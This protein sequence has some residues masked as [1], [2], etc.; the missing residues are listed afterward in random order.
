MQSFYDHDKIV[1]DVRQAVLGALEANGVADAYNAL[2]VGALLE[3]F[4]S[5]IKYQTIGSPLTHDVGILGLRAYEQSRL[6]MRV[7]VAQ[8]PQSLIVNPLMEAV[9]AALARSRKPMGEATLRRKAVAIHLRRP[10]LSAADLRLACIE[11]AS[12]EPALGS[13]LHHLHEAGIIRRNPDKGTWE[14][15]DV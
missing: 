7:A 14:I 8:S 10:K 6:A 13:A 12:L 5:E 9:A 1:T 4:A 2:A 3:A 11:D 15:A